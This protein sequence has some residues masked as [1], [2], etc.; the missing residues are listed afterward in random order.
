[1][2][3]VIAM[4][5]F[6]GSLS[7]MEAGT[8]VRNGILAARP[9]ANDQIVLKPMADGGEGTVDALIKGLNG[10]YRQATVTGP[11]GEKVTAMYGILP[12]RTTAV[13]ETAAA[14]GLDL[15]PADK[16]NPFLTTSFG[17]GELI[18]DAVRQGC[19]D[20]IIG[21]GGSATNDC[22]LGMLTSLG[23][24][25]TDIEGKRCGITGEDLSKVAAIDISDAYPKLQ[26]CTFR[27]ACDVRNP[28]YGPTGASVTFGPQKGATATQI[29]TLDAAM[30]T[31]SE[32]AA[33]TFKG[34]C[35][36]IAG[37]GAAG[38]LGYALLQFLN[39]RLESGSQ[40]V[41][42]A[43]DLDKDICRSQLVFTGEGRLDSQTAM[44][45]APAAIAALGKKYNKKVIA[46]CGALGEGANECLE[47]GISAVYEATPHGMPLRQALIKETAI[48]NL[49]ALTQR[50]MSNYPNPLL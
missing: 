34:S 39:A 38:G 11:L 30:M 23:F 37:T 2:R 36:L 16:R 4:D 7:S 50:V 32:L 48:A 14:I 15:V 44:G 29:A 5:S 33:A 1:M 40:L 41:L 20:F 49:T 8:A 18:R 31:F 25:F 28:L 9:D 24:I 35:H 43:L 12:S 26:G 19:N 21:L 45:K 27:V 42:K 3:I 13:I 46:L 17:V 47:N 22:G 6:K 10:V